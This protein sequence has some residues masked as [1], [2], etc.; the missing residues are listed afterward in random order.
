ML[1][2]H[3]WQAGTFAVL[4]REPSGQLS[5]PVGMGFV[6]EHNGEALLVTCQHVLNNIEGQRIAVTFVGCPEPLYFIAEQVE[7]FRLLA[8]DIPNDGLRVNEQ[9]YPRGVFPSGLDLAVLRLTGDLRGRVPEGV[10]AL[11]VITSNSPRDSRIEARFYHCEEHSSAYNIDPEFGTLGEARSDLPCTKVE[12][13]QIGLGDSGGAIWDPQRGGVVGIYLSKFEKRPDIGVSFS[14]LMLNSEVLELVIPGFQP[15]RIDEEL[16]DYV[17]RIERYCRELGPLESLFLDAEDDIGELQFDDVYRAPRLHFLRK[18]I[19]KSEKFVQE[20]SGASDKGSPISTWL[21]ANENSIVLGS[22]NRGKSTLLRHLASC[23]WTEPTKIGLNQPYIPVLM[24]CTEILDHMSDD[25]LHTIDSAVRAGA[26]RSLKEPSY[27][28]RSGFNLE[29]WCQ[30]SRSRALV[31]VDGF[32][33]VSETSRNSLKKKFTAWARRN[34]SSCVGRLVIA[35]RFFRQLNWPKLQEEFEYFELSELDQAN[36]HGLAEIFVGGHAEHFLG[37]LSAHRRGMSTFSPGLL[38]LACAAYNP[39][40]EQVSLSVSQT[41]ERAV[42]ALVRNVDR[43]YACDGLDLNEASRI[44]QRMKADD[45]ILDVL[46]AMAL[47]S[48]VDQRDDEGLDFFRLRKNLTVIHTSHLLPRD[49]SLTASVIEELGVATG[50]FAYD[51]KTLKVTWAHMDFRDYLAGQY[52]WALYLRN[53]EVPE[54]YE[55]FWSDTH[56]E[57]IIVFF[58]MRMSVNGRDVNAF[59][60]NMLGNESVRES[61][62]VQFLAECIKNG[63][64]IDSAYRKRIFTWLRKEIL[65]FDGLPDNSCIRAFTYANLSPLGVFA[66]LAEDPVAQDIIIDSALDPRVTVTFAARS[67]GILTE[68]GKLNRFFDRWDPSAESRKQ[69]RTFDVVSVLAKLEKHGQP[70]RVDIA[71][72]PEIIREEYLTACQM[73][74]SALNLVDST[75]DPGAIQDGMSALVDFAETCLQRDPHWGAFLGWLEA[76][77]P[78]HATHG[79]RLLEYLQTQRYQQ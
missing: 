33:E 70:I 17:V 13:T 72:L 36:A 6:V 60:Q 25:L 65:R 24:R 46:M 75:V 12:S 40:S 52:L 47:T 79:G 31:L 62:R 1:S 28:D 7:E 41:L 30:R 55:K 35:S 37:R 51:N 4:V 39:N 48:F 8:D 58:L 67:L 66:A 23:A 18:K 42:S 32:D 19:A 53:E 68:V 9:D 26:L 29:Q 78:Q 50:L 74:E 76:E 77:Y 45:L 34:R 3:G 73:T 44:V 43:Y 14:G 57:S 69:R 16:A 54:A 2:S 5:A 63:V 27:F 56:G 11:P 38:I 49:D 20:V 21:R 22:A 71:Q 64:R 15:K 59:L 61:Q 10:I